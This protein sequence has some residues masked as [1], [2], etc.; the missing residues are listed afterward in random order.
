MERA[1]QHPRKFLKGHSFIATKNCSMDLK[2]LQN[3]I[4][5]HGGEVRETPINSISANLTFPAV[6]IPKAD[7]ATRPRPFKL[8]HY[9]I[10]GRQT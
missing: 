2:L 6:D 8:P 1:Q 10:H 7:Q 5:A 3:I 9:L 4:A